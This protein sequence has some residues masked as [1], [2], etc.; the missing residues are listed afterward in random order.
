M[1]YLEK[2]QALNGPLEFSEIIGK[3]S[4]KEDSSHYTL[5]RLSKVFR[6]ATKMMRLHEI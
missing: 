6:E 2:K 4:G 1:I 3:S 5:F